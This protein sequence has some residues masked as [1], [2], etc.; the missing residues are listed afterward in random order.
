MEKKTSAAIIIAAKMNVSII[1][2]WN[3][4]KKV[5]W[6]LRKLKRDASFLSAQEEEREIQKSKLFERLKTMHT[7]HSS[8][9]ISPQHH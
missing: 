6:Q 3:G 9:I 8:W 4:K 2:F 1:A 5:S 7:S